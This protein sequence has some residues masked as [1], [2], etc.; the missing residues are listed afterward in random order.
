MERS[1]SAIENYKRIIADVY[2]EEQ[3]QSLQVLKNA[4]KEQSAEY[5]D[6]KARLNRI[7]AEICGP[8]INKTTGAYLAK[9][10]YKNWGFPDADSLMA[11]IVDNDGVII[12]DGKPIV[13]QTLQQ[14]ASYADYLKKNL[15]RTRKE[16]R[17][18]VTECEMLL[19][20]WIKQ[21]LPVDAVKDTAFAKFGITDE[22]EKAAIISVVTAETGK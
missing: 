10:L 15:T 13:L 2:T 20:S 5:Q 12:R 17:D 11:L 22:T 18:R 1:T 14:M 21:G 16:Q 9:A 4:I 7:E 19:Q 6:A 8:L 3:E